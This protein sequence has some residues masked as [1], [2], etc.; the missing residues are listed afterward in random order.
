[1]EEESEEGSEEEIFTSE[2]EEMPF[3]PS[4]EYSLTE[5][6]SEED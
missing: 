1:M 5:E 6:S 2:D 3:E 4:Q